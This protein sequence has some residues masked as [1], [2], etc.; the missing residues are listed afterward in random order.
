MQTGE[1]AVEHDDV[2]GVEAEL[3]GGVES[4]VSDVDGHAGVAQAFGHDVG[5]RP[6]VLNDED[7]HC[8]CSDL[9]A[10]RCGQRDHDS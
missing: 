6:V 2:V 7:P 8:S 5:E 4:V 9:D 3:G 1:V 10:G